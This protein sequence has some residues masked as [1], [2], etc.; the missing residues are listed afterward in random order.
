VADVV[1]D[2]DEFVTGIVVFGTHDPQRAQALADRHAGWHAPD[3]GI[4]AAS[5]ERVWWRDGFE[6]GRRCW[7]ADEVKG[8]AAVWFREFAEY[9]APVAD[10]AEAQ[11]THHREERA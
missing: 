1:T 9:Q 6:S 7:I 3:G 5:P 11:R 2:E 10:A 4:V 8:R